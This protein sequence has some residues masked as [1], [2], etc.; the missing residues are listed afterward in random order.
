MHFQYAFCKICYTKKQACD[1]THCTA[2]LPISKDAPEC[3][4]FF[5]QWDTQSYVHVITTVCNMCNAILRNLLFL[6]TLWQLH[7][8]LVNL[9]EILQEQ[10]A[11]LVE[12]LRHWISTFTTA[13]YLCQVCHRGIPYWI[14]SNLTL[15]QWTLIYDMAGWPLS[16]Q[17]QYYYWNSSSVHGRNDPRCRWVLPRKPVTTRRQFLWH[18]WDTLDPEPFQHSGWGIPIQSLPLTVDPGQIS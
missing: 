8:I 4:L 15:G 12:I 11:N 16:F 17:H 13:C 1:I 14:C 6:C 5:P 9:E 18:W 7:L 2:C 3:P 10:S